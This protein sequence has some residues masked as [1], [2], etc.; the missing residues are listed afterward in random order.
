[1]LLLAGL[2]GCS[3]SVAP[4]NAS[5]DAGTEG[6][7][8]SLG[9]CSASNAAGRTCAEYSALAGADAQ[10]AKQGCTGG[11][12]TWSDA[13]C[14]RSGAVGGCQE[15]MAGLNVTVWYYMGN[16]TTAATVMQACS[17][18][19][20]TFVPAS[21]GTTGGCGMGGAGCAAYTDCWHLRQSRLHR[22]SGSDNDLRNG[23]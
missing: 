18:A 15:V 11:G 5:G 12:G 7:A 6:G 10:T 19:G 22:L 8:G 3:S 13:G 4:G 2:I 17:I 21:G 9:A 14:D 1:M 16:G 23:Q 20:G